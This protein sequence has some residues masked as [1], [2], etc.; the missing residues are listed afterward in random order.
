M[1]TKFFCETEVDKSFDKFMVII[2]LFYDRCFPLAQRSK[3]E[4]KRVPRMPW[5]T[6]S[7]LRSINKKNRLFCRYKAKQT[8]ESKSSILNIEIY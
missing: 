6:Q 7:L 8:D 5:V 2:V 3:Q 1:E 4:Y